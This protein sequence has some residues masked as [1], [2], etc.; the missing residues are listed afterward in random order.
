MEEWVCGIMESRNATEKEEF[1]PIVQLNVL[2]G[3]LWRTR[4]QEVVLGMVETALGNAS[5]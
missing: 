2:G 5:A 4:K 1:D 3:I